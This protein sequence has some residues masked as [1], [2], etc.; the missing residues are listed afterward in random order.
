MKTTFTASTLRGAQE[1][2][3]RQIAPD[4]HFHRVFD[5]LPDVHFYAKNRAG[6]I[7]FCSPGLPVHLGLTSAAEALG[8]TDRDLTPGVLAEAYVA[9]DAE[10]YRTGLPLPP[11]VVVWPDDVGLPDLYLSGKYPV[12]NRKGKVIGI[13]GTL[14]KADNTSP[15]SQLGHRLDAA[16]SLLRADLQAFPAIELLAG[17]CH[18]S[19]RHFQRVFRDTF[20]MSP[21]TYWMKLRIRAACESLRT[22]DD[23]LAQLAARLGFYD[24]SSFARH[25]RK[26]TGKTPRAF[27]REGAIAAPARRK[28]QPLPSPLPVPKYASQKS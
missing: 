10:V 28:P 3:L 6:Q 11:R 16:I 25:F 13:M 4:A 20:G 12:K 18:L 2:F 5:A 22:G 8:M 23:T 21:Y 15:T 24:Q 9:E 17:C 7:L 26:H 19:I 27:A 1:V 14:R